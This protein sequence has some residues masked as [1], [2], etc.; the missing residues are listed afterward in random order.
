M[1]NAYSSSDGH[2]GCIVQLEGWPHVTCHFAR[3]YL[4]KTVLYD[5]ND[6]NLFIAQSCLDIRTSCYLYT[7]LVFNSMFVTAFVCY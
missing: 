7:R 3:L 2:L 1:Y 4:F 5:S 6:V